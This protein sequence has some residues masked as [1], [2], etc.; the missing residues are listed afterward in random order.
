MNRKGI[1]TIS[2]F[3]KDVKLQL[4]YLEKFTPQKQIQKNAIFCGSGDSL[5]AAMLAEAFSNYNSKSCDPLELAKNPKI[6]SGKT[7]YFVS[8]S[9]N[10]IS[11]IRA[12]Q[13]VISSTAVTRN[14]K[15]KIANACKSVIPLD[16]ADSGILTAGTVGFLSSALACISLVYDLKISGV[17]CLFESAKTNS[18]KVSLRNKVY[19]LGNQF[20][21]PIAMYAS[22]KLGEVLGMDSRYERIEQFSHM[23]LFAAKK[24]DTVVILEPKNKHNSALKQN[25]KKLGLGVYVFDGPADKIKQVLFYTF[26]V[27]LLALKLARKRNLT[28]CYFIAQKKIRTAS[29]NMI[30]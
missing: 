11:N 14:P 27:Q 19:F 15:S 13:L 23:G 20:T 12:A 22:A 5:C 30:Y 18:G 2:A 3:E 10:T 4:D 24:G 9:G 21:F 8:I 1:D 26:L 17:K 6:A 25:L 29:S 16:Y 28:D 7:T